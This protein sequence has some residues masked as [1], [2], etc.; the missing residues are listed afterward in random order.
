[1]TELVRFFFCPAR[2]LRECQV[3]ELV[4]SKA[5]GKKHPLLSEIRPSFVI[6]EMNWPSLLPR[7]FQSRSGS[8]ACFL[9]KSTG[10]S[11]WPDAVV[12]GRALSGR[13]G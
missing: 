7:V 1:M 3:C 10:T 13:Q 11:S 9:R 5:N 4:E 8:Y 2:L 12:I 6:E